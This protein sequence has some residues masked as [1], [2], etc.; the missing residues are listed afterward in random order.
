M[1][2]E[3]FHRFDLHGRALQV[4]N[5]RLEVLAA[6]VA[7]ADTPHYKAQDIDFR[8]AMQSA[9]DELAVRAT[10]DRHL[11]V[12][13]GAGPA[14][15]RP[16]A[17]DQPAVD[18]NT[19]DTQRENAAIAETAVRYQASLTFLSGHIRTLRDALTGGR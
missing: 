7:N 10:N 9:G 18:G 6:N 12:G 5:Q 15:P 8:A 19:V 1:A 17:A 11:S 13:G 16:R 4:H 3:I 14:T 2:L